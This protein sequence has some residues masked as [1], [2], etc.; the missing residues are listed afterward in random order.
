MTKEKILG[1]YEAISK[2]AE[3]I[4]KNSTDCG[5]CPF[6][7]MHTSTVV[8]ETGASLQTGCVMALVQFTVEHN[9]PKEDTK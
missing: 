7:A 2:T 5:G 3:I 8:L 6:C 4:C 9:L 1:M